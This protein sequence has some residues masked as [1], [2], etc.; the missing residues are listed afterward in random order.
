MFDKWVNQDIAQG[1]LTLLY[2]VNALNCALIALWFGW[3]LQ[4]NILKEVADSFCNKMG[5]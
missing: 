3:H 1:S 5:K 2:M 4:T